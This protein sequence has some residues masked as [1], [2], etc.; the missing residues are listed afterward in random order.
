MYQQT[1]R[2]RYVQGS[3]GRQG[4]DTVWQYL[5]VYVVLSVSAVVIGTAKYAWAY[6]TSIRASRVMFDGVLSGV[7]RAPLPWL[8]T[9]PVG[10]I[11]NRFTADF[12][13]LDSRLVNEIAEFLF[14][15]LELFGISIAG[16]LVSPIMIVFAGL[17]TGVAVMIGRRYLSGAREV[18]RL[19]SIARSPILVELFD[20][21]RAGIATITAY[22][23]AERYINR[24]DLFRVAHRLS[25]PSIMYFWW[26]IRLVADD[27]TRMQQTIDSYTTALMHMW[28]FNQWMSFRLSLLAASFAALLAVLVVLSPGIDASLAGFALAF[29]LRYNDAIILTIRSYASLEMDMNAT[30]GVVERTQFQTESLNRCDAPA[31]WPYKGHLKVDGL[32]AGYAPGLPPVLKRLSLTVEKNQTYRDRRKNRCRQIVVRISPVSLSRST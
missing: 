20:C 11:L 22:D 3:T 26:Y 5:A 29:A 9:V 6:A 30:E 18:K 21:V 17:S 4:S 28:L 25:Q 27:F 19:E 31:G 10:R 7:F 12:S 16:F 13:V 24:Y 8:D 32:V 1:Y 23:Q 15:L 14:P 2:Q